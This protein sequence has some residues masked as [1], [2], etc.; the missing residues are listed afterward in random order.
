MKKYGFN[1]FFLLLSLCVF[2]ACMTVPVS[3]RKAFNL[4][5]E[6]LEKS[7]GEQ[8][9][10]ATI[11][12]EPLSQ[13]KRLVEMVTKVGKRIAAVAD[14]PDYQWEFKLIDKDVQ[15]AFCLP[16]GKIA[17]YKG[18]LPIAK[19]EA[20][21]A[22]VM[23]HEVVHAIARHGGQRISAGLGITA[24]IAALERTALKNNKNAPYIMAALG[25]AAT[26]GIILPYSRMQ[27]SEADEIGQILMARAGY[28]P[29]ESIAFW[30]R[31]GAVTKGGSVPELLS[32]HPS[33]KSREENMKNHLPQAMKEYEKTLT[34]YDRGE[35]F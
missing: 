11:S 17:I 20:G 29:A 24:G 13:D 28:N 15:N 30:N 9:Y 5:P 14:K 33:S 2:Q 10:T 26:G 6:S 8:S 7:L 35:N 19:N 23:A 3:G 27:E 12:K 4:I 25:I 16:G 34:K 31:F 22:T 21:L 18:I 1:S 32:T